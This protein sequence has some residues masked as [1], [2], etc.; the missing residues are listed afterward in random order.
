MS[1]NNH[2]LAMT[3]SLKK[4]KLTNRPAGVS[5]TWRSSLVWRAGAAIICWFA[6]GVSTACAAEVLTCERHAVNWKWQEFRC[7]VTINTEGQKMLFKADFSGSHDD[8]RLSMALSLDG[9]P[10]ACGQNSKTS[11]LA[12]D[13][14]V[15]LECH[16]VPGGAPG[17]KTMLAAIIQI[18]HAQLDAIT[19]SSP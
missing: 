10:V 4:N 16:F 19:L 3:L 14:N 6:M 7:P 11:L 1:C 13:G 18:W 2:R 5:G 17:T 12:E 8:T 15:S 9:V